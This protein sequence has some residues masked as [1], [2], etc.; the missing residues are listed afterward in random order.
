M[1]HFHVCFSFIKFQLKLTSVINSHTYKAQDVKN[2]YND[3]KKKSHKEASIV[4]S[5]WEYIDPTPDVHA[6]F[7]QFD[8]RFFWG[9]LRSV[10]VRWSR[11]M[12]L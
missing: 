12:T 2:K 7:I 11:R 10:E 3:S 9:K 4:D 5:S 6:L 1:F 8:N